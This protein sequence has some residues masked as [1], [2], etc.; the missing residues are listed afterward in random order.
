MLI[1]LVKY[2]RCALSK[3][4]ICAPGT[5]THEDDAHGTNFPPTKAL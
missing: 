4:R 3:Q 2:V 5:N 1:Y